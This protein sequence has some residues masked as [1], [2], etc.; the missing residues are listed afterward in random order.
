MNHGPGDVAQPDLRPSA[1]RGDGEAGEFLGLDR[2]RQ[3]GVAEQRLRDAQLADGRA[4]TLR[5]QPSPSGQ[6]REPDQQP[7]TG[8]PDVLLV[9]LRC[10]QRGS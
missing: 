10:E 8:P 4:E 3:R 5:D 7:Q 6:K 2:R 9:L 1:T